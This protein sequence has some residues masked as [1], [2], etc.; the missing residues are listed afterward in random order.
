VYFVGRGAT[1]VPGVY[2]NFTNPVP[3][4]SFGY[5]SSSS[6]GTTE[7]FYGLPDAPFTKLV[8]TLAGGTNS[9]FTNGTLCTTPGSVKGSFLPWSGAAVVHKTATMGCS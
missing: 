1:A 2:L 8:V 6:A 9:L 5:G 7:A 4:S 3:F